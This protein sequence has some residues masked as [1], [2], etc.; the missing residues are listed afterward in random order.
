[1][2]LCD[3]FY[4]DGHVF[5]IRTKM[6]NKFLE[7]R[8]SLKHTNI[9]YFVYVQAFM[10]T[11]VHLVIAM[12]AGGM[13]HWVGQCW[14]RNNLKSCQQAKQNPRVCVSLFV[15]H[16]WCVSVTLSAMFSNTGVVLAEV[17][18]RM[19]HGHLPFLFYLR[20]EQTPKQFCLLL[21]RLTHYC[22]VL[23][24]KCYF[25]VNKIIKSINCL[26]LMQCISHNSC[27]G[28]WKSHNLVACRTEY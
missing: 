11:A 22:W 7:I 6:L 5:F 8:N 16:S 1:M 15:H 4:W 20:R 26:D 27:W 25:K 3:A 12:T 17:S 24:G 13:V 19:M 18:E 2:W 9:S 10:C 21:S 14:L 23:F 28:L